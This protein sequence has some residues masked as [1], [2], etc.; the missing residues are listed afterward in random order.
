VKYELDLIPRTDLSALESFVLSHSAVL[1]PRHSLIVAAK[2]TL[3][4]GY[5]RFRAA[6]SNAEKERKV[7]LCR[8]VLQVLRILETG[9]ATRIGSLNK[10]TGWHSD[11]RTNV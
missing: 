5:G 3:S 2:Q 8:E 11:F 1:H 6:A 9:I 10:T 7:D 4:V